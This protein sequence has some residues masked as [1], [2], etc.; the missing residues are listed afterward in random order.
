MSDAASLSRAALKPL[1]GTEGKAS[2]YSLPALQEQLPG[3]SR[4][5]ISLRIVLESVLRNSDGTRITDEHV[6][7]LANWKPDG[8]RAEEIP[9][10]VGRI[11]LNCAAGIPLLGDLT[12]IREA[13]AA[14]GGDPE[15][16]QP[17]VRVDM[18]LDHTMT[19]DFHGT[20]DA[21]A[22]NMALDVERNEERYRFVKWAMQAY[23]GIRLFPPGSGILH[24]LNL[25]F[26]APGL[27]AKNGVL[28]PDT[29]VGTDSH[30]C[31]IAGLGSLGWGVGGIEAQAALLGQ[32]IFFLTPDVVGVHVTG[33]MREGVTATDL[34]LHL[35]RMLREARVVGKLVEFFGPAVATL[36][37]PDRATVANMAP[38]YGATVGYFPVD[39]QTCRY[40]R[41][42]GRAEADVAAFEAYYRAQGMFGAPK[43]GEVDYSQTL[44]LRLDDIVPS[45]RR[46]EAAA[47][48][49]CAARGQGAVRAAPR[50]ADRGW[51]LRQGAGSGPAGTR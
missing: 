48:P 2:F 28:Y 50:H 31:M 16:V 12:A 32:P 40:L 45:S 7:S 46:P 43:A 22:K 33:R 13:L 41:Y 42:T 6:R 25:E 5:P 47:G 20:A 29:L 11:V 38:E 8:V 17:V 36:T 35:T 27:L 39:E 24:Q 44:E 26:F 21:M 30:T 23:D 51:W 37:V 1:P 14:D 34:V 9:F 4:L 18:A 15:T 10:T 19:V 3:I 49:G